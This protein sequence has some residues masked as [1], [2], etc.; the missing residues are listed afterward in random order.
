MNYIGSKFSLLDFLD[1]NIAKAVGKELGDLIFCDIFAGTGAVGA[2]FKN[3]VKKLISNDTQ[4]YSYVLNTHYIKSDFKP[5]ILTDIVS[6]LNNLVGIKGKIYQFYAL[7]GGLDRQYF[8]NEN[9]CKID[10]IREEISKLKLSDDIY[11]AL[12]ASLLESADKVANTASVYGAFLK[13]LKKSAQKQLKFEL[14]NFT[15]SVNKNEV[16]QMDANELI[17]QISGDIL[18]LDPPYN[19]REYGANYHI[20]NTIALYD[21]FIPQGKTG[22]RKYEKSQWCK[23]NSAHIAFE[24]LIKNA[25]FKYIFLSYNNEGIISC[26]KVREIMQKY[27]QYELFTKDYKRF[28]ADRNRIHK[29]DKTIEFLHFLQK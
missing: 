18:Y 16:Y 4:F 13:K 22:L 5:E 27:G 19:H 28:K 23:K 10:A 21:E 9:A 6:N 3:K 29:A 25:N 26:D 24:N 14:A 1:E 8:S 11:F 2:Y 12:L 7:G 15:P 17:T 20:L